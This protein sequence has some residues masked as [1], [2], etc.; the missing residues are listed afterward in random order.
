MPGPVGPNPSSRSP[1]SRPLRQ[2]HDRGGTM[3][4][5]SF[6]RA[7]GRVR[8]PRRDRLQPGVAGQ[9]SATTARAR[10]T[11]RSRSTTSTAS[12]T[13]RTVSPPRPRDAPLDVTRVG[14]RA[15]AIPQADS[16]ERARRP[17]RQR[18]RAGRAAGGLPR[19]RPAEEPALDV[20]RRLEEPAVPR[21]VPAAH[22]QVVRRCAARRPRPPSLR[23]LRPSRPGCSGPT[24]TRTCSQR[25]SRR[26]TADRITA[27]P[28]RRSS[29]RA[30]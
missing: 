24:R 26:S 21:R 1:H 20:R 8:L 4:S 5:L 28:A 2:R 29:G 15:A 30:Q 19:G 6:R 23:G 25:S 27:R 9:A 12:S 7:H 11:S 22:V 17:P 3:T 13:T 14:L 10:S 18:R 16:R